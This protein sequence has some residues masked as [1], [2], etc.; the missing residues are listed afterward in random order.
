MDG[1]E[2]HWYWQKCGLGAGGKNREVRAGVLKEA[3][4]L[5]ESEGGDHLD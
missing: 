1:A 5:L 4:F 2:C 3:A